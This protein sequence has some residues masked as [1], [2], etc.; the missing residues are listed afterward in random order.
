MKYG[1]L[2]IRPFMFAT[3]IYLGVKPSE[4]YTFAII[5]TPAG[6]YYPKPLSVKVETEYSRACPGGTGFSKAAG[7]YAGSMLP[8]KLAHKEGFD[9]LIWTDAIEHTYIEESG[10]MNIFFVK[11][12]GSLL[13]PQTSD[14]ILK[15]IT[16]DTII[17]LAK[18]DAIKVEERL[19]SINEI[20]EGISSGDIVEVFG[21]GTAV[22]VSYIHTITLDEK[23][24]TL[25]E[26]NP[27]G[28]L[29][30]SK[31]EDL[32]SGAASDTENWVTVL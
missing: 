26:H 21:V 23:K 5:M 6:E 12:D 22:N 24:Y 28:E 17:A 20:V 8:T 19:I 25:P 30:K 10:T 32:R 15:G 1:S 7:N 2:Y 4:T 11:K 31:L 3:D 13:T 9:Q 18:R 16:R 27:I 14:T 29:F